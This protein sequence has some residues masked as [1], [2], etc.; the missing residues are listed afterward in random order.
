MNIWEKKDEFSYLYDVSRVYMLVKGA[1]GDVTIATPVSARIRL[2]NR[3]AKFDRQLFRSLFGEAPFIDFELR[4][5][6]HPDMGFFRVRVKDDAGGFVD[7]RER[8]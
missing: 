5:S 7:I 3:D 1:S 4:S 6:R 2:P 8:P